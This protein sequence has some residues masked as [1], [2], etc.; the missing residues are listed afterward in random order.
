MRIMIDTNILISIYL[1][2]TPVMRNLVDTI[3]EKHTIVLPSYVI[4]E[5]K[6]VIKRKFP[7][8]YQYLD[9]FLREVPYEY[10]YTVEKIDA[11]KY[12]N[13]RDKKDLPAIIEDVDILITGDKDFAE[14]EIEKPEILTPAQFLKKYS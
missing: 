2:P 8:Q 11:N 9:A 1:F 6:T 10:T 7:A 5:L 4:D 12:P 13:I 3:T 14:L